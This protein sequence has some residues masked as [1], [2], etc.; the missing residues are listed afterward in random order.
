MEG[1][2]LSLRRCSLAMEL[3]ASYLTSRP[4]IHLS[5]VD[6]I[7]TDLMGTDSNETRHGGTL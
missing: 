3:W 2:A 7:T 6:I 1:L 5:T 4:S